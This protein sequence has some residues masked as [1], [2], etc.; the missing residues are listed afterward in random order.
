MRNTLLNLFCRG[1]NGDETRGFGLFVLCNE[2]ESL[3]A[4]LGTNGGGEDGLQEGICLLPD[5]RETPSISSIAFWFVFDKAMDTVMLCS[6]GHSR[7]L[8]CSVLLCSV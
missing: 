1:N 2:T 8:S 3:Q 5:E 4:H 6:A 7:V